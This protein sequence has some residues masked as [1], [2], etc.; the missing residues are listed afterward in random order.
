MPVRLVELQDGHCV[1]SCRSQKIPPVVFQ[2]FATRLVSVRHHKSIME[3]REK[4]PDLSFLVFDDIAADE[5]M[6]QSWGTHP[7][8]QI[9]RK[10]LFPQIRSDI[11][12]Y[13]IVLDRGGYY[14]DINKA[15]TQQVT[16]LHDSNSSGVISFEP[17]L[18]RPWPS[19]EVAEFVQHPDKVVIQ[20]AFGFAPG[21]P[22][23]ARAIDMIVRNSDWVSK[24]IFD[25]VR[26]AIVSFTGPGVFT[27][28]VLDAVRAGEFDGVEQLGVDFGARGVMRVP[29]SNTTPL[30][31][32]HYSKVRN[33]PILA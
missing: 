11:F 7:V 20:W 12:R 31:G 30:P 32:V 4:N 21:H 17:S 18:T 10:A 16:S 29:G 22:I 27:A 26:A 5:Y 33:A 1:R 13:C 8:F 14:V 25:S 19:G 24:R 23:L 28:A 15:I 3:F 2:T 6:E 9:Y